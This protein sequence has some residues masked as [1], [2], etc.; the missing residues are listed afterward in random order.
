MSFNINALD[1]PADITHTDEDKNLNQKF[2]V[3]F[4]LMTMCQAKGFCLQI[5]FILSY[6]IYECLFTG[7]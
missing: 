4:H 5:L 3:K 6:K 7:N 2:Q 1:S